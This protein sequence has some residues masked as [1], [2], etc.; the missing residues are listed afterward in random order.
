MELK[1]DFD[2]HAGQAWG[3]HHDQPPRAFQEWFERSKPPVRD[4]LR[5]RISV[6]ARGVRGEL[7]AESRSGFVVLAGPGSVGAV[8]VD[9][10]PGRLAGS[11]DDAGGVVELCIDPADE[12]GI[13]G[14]RRLDLLKSGGTSGGG[15]VLLFKLF[16]EFKELPPEFTGLL[17]K[18][19]K[20]RLVVL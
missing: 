6:V 10:N 14:N 9:R 4:I 19:L 12:R 20:I 18:S 3:V 2:R 13:V 11:P 5:E 16:L 7:I 15:S 1:Q 8:A 17:S